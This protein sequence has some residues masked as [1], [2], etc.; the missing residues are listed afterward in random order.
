MPTTVTAPL[1]ARNLG[2]DNG[3]QAEAADCKQRSRNISTELLGRRL[4]CCLW[5]TQRPA[6]SG[7]VQTKTDHPW[8]PGELACST[9][10]RLFQTEV[11][12]Y[13]RVTGKQVQTEEDKALASWF[14]RNTHYYH[15]TEAGSDLWGKGLGKGFDEMTREYWKGLFAHGYGLCYATHAQWLGGDISGSCRTDSLPADTT[16]DCHHRHHHHQRHRHENNGDAIVS[17][18]IVVVVVVV[19]VVVIVVSSRHGHLLLRR[20]TS[21]YGVTHV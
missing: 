9:F 3:L 13:A 20:A 14:W 16:C 12:V 6:A 18:R 2:R 21:Y 11:Q 8:Y 5:R 1:A 15:S 7:D 10:P 19:V 4:S 17:N